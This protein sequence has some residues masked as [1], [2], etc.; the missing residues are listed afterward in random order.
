MPKDE[1]SIVGYECH[2]NNET[3]TIYRVDFIIPDELDIFACGRFDCVNSF[4][5]KT[6]KL[7]S[8]Y[9]LMKIGERL[10]L[11][12]NCE[13]SYEKF[14]HLLCDSNIAMNEVVIE[15]L[16]LSCE[17]YIKLFKSSQKN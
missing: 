13:H 7:S 11:S 5:P 4:N 6:R 15:E 16:K 10:S 3:H 17:Y 9:G 1:L 8:E 2:Y 14:I 12:D